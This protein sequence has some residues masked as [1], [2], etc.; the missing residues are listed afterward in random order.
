MAAI[1]PPLVHLLMVSSSDAKDAVQLASRHPDL[2]REARE[3][4]ALVQR[5]AGPMG[6]VDAMKALAP[7]MLHFDPRQFGAGKAGT[8][9]T[10]AWEKSFADALADLPAEALEVA[11][12][13]WIKVGKW[14]PKV[15]ELRELAEPKA[16]E[17]RTLAW[18]LR[19]VAEKAR[20]PKPPITPEERAEIQR[21]TAALVADLKSGALFAG[22]PSG[23][24]APPLRSR[25]EVAAGLRAM[26]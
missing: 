8:M 4:T 21:Q 26:A 3:V 22:K 16:K 14:F 13:A 17:I 11:V 6:T 10:D 24:H 18:R 23:I 15:A 19:S 9:L 12:S 2:I 7:L 20:L 1:S 5:M 25:A